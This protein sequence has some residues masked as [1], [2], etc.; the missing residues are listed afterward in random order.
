MYIMIKRQ[1]LQ[2]HWVT[3]P[4][5]IKSGLV[6]GTGFRE[7]IEARSIIDLIAKYQ[8]RRISMEHME[9]RAQL[10]NVHEISKKNLEI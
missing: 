7:N 1:S 2:S 9:P 10:E 6:G 8:K 3:T 5:Y 4:Q